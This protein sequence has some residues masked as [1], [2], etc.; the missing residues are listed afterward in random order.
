M[1]IIDYIFAARP[2]LHLPVWSVYL[3][4]L[5][6]HHQL[7]NEPF[8]NIDLLLLIALTLV[9]SSAY[10][11]NQIYDYDS[12]K[13]NNKLGFLQNQYISF[14]EMKTLY[15]VTAILSIAVGFYVSKNSGFLLTTLVL[16]GGLYSVPPFRLKDRPFL[17]LLSNAIGYGFIVPMLV[18]PN[19]GMHNSGLFK[20]NILYYFMLTIGAIYLLTTIPDKEGDKKSGKKTVAV[21]LPSSLIKLLAC[22]L[23]IDS[24]LIAYNSDYQMLFILSIIS[25][26]VTIV[27]LINKSEKLLFIAIKLPILLLTLLAGYFFYYYAVF[28]V[29]LII[30]TRLYYKKRFNMEYPKLT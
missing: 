16:L 28:I 14:A 13:L 5:Y 23:L 12:D 27:S 6:Y 4:T 1:K 30:G 19:L 21:L 25:T 22:M 8:T 24:A 15:Y 2:L 7:T 20:W 29:A 26:S 18:M 9:S 11:I 17:G 10:Y 3:V